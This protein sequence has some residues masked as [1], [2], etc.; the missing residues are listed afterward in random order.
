MEVEMRNAKTSNE[1]RDERKIKASRENKKK[2]KEEETQSLD[3][4]PPVWNCA[5]LRRL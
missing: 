3:R 1:A 4:P 5:A 2:K